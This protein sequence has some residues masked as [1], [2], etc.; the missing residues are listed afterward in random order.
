M[1]E[2]RQLLGGWFTGVAAVADSLVLAQ[3][4][5]GH[6]IGALKVKG[7]FA[8]ILTSALAETRILL[9]FWFA[10]VSCKSS[11]FCKRLLPHSGAS[12]NAPASAGR[13]PDRRDSLRA[14]SKTQPRADNTWCAGSYTRGN[15]SETVADTFNVHTATIYRLSA[16]AAE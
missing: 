4:T 3:E 6:W 7:G 10:E 1:E 15:P 13:R 14:P 8:K 2:P 12:G 11:S 9:G 5:D 16:T